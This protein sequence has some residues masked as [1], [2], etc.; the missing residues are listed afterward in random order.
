M[1]I[2]D[3]N[4]TAPVKYGWV[5]Q[6]SQRGTFD[7]IWACLLVLI[8]STWTV[9]HINVPGND[10]SFWNIQVRRFRWA[11]YALLAPEM[12]VIVSG[13]QYL[14][15]KEGREIMNGIG[16]THWTI[17][18]G[19]FADSGGF[20]LCPPDVPPFPVNNRGLH[21][22]VKK[23]YLEAP[24]ISRNEIRDRSK[25]DVFVKLFACIQGFYMIVQC[26]ARRIQNLEISC[27]ELSTVAFAVCT[28]VSYSLWMNKPLSVEVAVPIEMT[29]TMAQVL[30][31]AGPAASVL[32][33]DTP[34]DFVEQPGWRAW[35]RRR[36]FAH[37]SGLSKR[38]LERFPN[39]YGFEPASV[40]PPL[41]MSLVMSLYGAIHI[42]GWNF[43]FPTRI[44]M[45]IWRIASITS[46][47]NLFFSGLVEALTLKP[48]FNFDMTVLGVWEH[49]SSKRTFW[50]RWA[51]DGPATLAA[52]VYFA[53]RLMLI[54]EMFA[55]LRLM[56][57]TAY[58]TVNWT[59]FIPH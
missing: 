31:E 55:S 54:G 29:I 11:F 21:Y 10:E 24:A 53:A 23:K 48:W 45:Q 34:M 51:M 28:A 40:K 36:R 18:H 8:S 44:D 33:E 2:T 47:V 4:A 13:L 49:K 57:S 52:M 7:I 16:I 19:H 9:V 6:P 1:Q 30:S 20:L 37:A 41:L 26:I 43:S 27:L 22:L 14:S 25:A 42:L 59:N 58:E 32:Y 35:R 17:V 5:D 46:F 12:L 56:D 39:D 15:A 50:R 3:S 38:P